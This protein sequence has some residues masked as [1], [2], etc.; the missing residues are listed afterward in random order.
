MAT[1]YLPIETELLARL[2]DAF[3]DHLEAN[4]CLA[5]ELDEVL[6]N[7]FEGDHKYGCVVEFGGGY[8][9][10]GRVFDALTWVWRFEG[11]F[12]IRYTDNETIETDMRS[13][14]LPLSNL[15]TPEY[16]RL[17]GTT[18][19][20]LVREIARPLLQQVGDV[21]FYWIPFV[22]EARAK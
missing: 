9:G 18:P 20:A 16:A 14:I 3:P 11:V 5:G 17:E 22:V 2:L 19:R 6:D 13:V 15:L 10:D 8:P 21:P 1:D 7:I 12:F 4:R